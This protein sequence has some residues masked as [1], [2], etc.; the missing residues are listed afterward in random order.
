MLTLSNRS[1]SN[2]LSGGGHK[3]FSEVVTTAINTDKNLL[4]FSRQRATSGRKFPDHVPS[5]F[6][7]F[8]PPANMH[9]RAGFALAGK[10]G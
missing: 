10:R 5:G 2:A 3:D 8:W 9:I 1:S 7:G 4:L 6:D